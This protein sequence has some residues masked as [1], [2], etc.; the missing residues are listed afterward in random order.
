MNED[1]YN[2][3]HSSDNSRGIIFALTGITYADKNYRIA[4]RNS[5]V[6]VIEYIIEGEGTIEVNGNVFHPKK[7]D[8]YLLPQGSSHVYYPNPNNPW[9]KIWINLSGQLISDC[10][11]AYGLDTVYLF[12]NLY[13]KD[14]LEEI[15][16][17]AKNKVPDLSLSTGKLVYEILYR[18]NMHNQRHEPVINPNARLMKDYIND[19]LFEPITLSTLSDLIGMSDQHTIRIFKSTFGS[20]PYQYILW[21]K[22]DYAKL[23][24]KNTNMSVKE[25]SQKLAFTDEFYF[26]NIFKK[27]IG[28]SPTDYRTTFMP[29][30]Q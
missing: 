5:D 7:G 19:H 14:L 29:K 9:K 11:N 16:N 8:T 28:I 20:T 26:S 17:N 2:F 3:D 6:T 21:K 24:L 12:N 13:T 4:R 27:K 22:I 25:I 15:V 10:I 18:M 1:I 30:S 23:Y